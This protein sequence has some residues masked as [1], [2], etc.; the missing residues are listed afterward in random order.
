MCDDDGGGEGVEWGGFVDGEEFG[1]EAREV[2]GNNGNV[3]GA[4][5][6]Q[7]NQIC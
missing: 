6:M 1:G 2:G 5:E 7:L 3:R 4:R